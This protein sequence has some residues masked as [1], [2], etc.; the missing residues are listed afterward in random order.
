[1]ERVK[2]YIDIISS[3]FIINGKIESK[4]IVVKIKKSP[5]IIIVSHHIQRY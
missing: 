5:E 4:I 1:M 3:L 2:R